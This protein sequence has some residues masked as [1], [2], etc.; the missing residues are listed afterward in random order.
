MIITQEIIEQVKTLYP[1]KTSQETGGAAA[2]KYLLCNNIGNELKS[3]S[4]DI[5]AWTSRSYT[6]NLYVTLSNL[7]N[8]L[9]N[10]GRIDL[11]NDISYLA[12]ITKEHAYSL[13][14]SLDDLRLMPA[15]YKDT[16][17]SKEIGVRRSFMALAC[18][19]IK[20]SDVPHI[21]D[22]NGLMTGEITIKG[23]G[24]RARTLTSKNNF[25]LNEDA[26]PELIDAIKSVIIR[27]DAQGSDMK[28]KLGQHIQEWEYTPSQVI[29][30]HGE[31]ML[32]EGKSPQEVADIQG[33]RVDSFKNR[34]IKYRRANQK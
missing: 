4:A 29:A 15:D 12:D 13:P 2:F 24:A 22:L 26:L 32:N 9:Q 33:I 1:N 19:G 7:V 23:K 17:L 3:L 20:P 28:N 34:Q 27:K 8:K 5:K 6:H 10:I 25:D 18:N 16:F 11:I 21:V 31:W 30:S 14:P